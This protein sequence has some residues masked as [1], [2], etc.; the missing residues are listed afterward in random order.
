MGEVLDFLEHI[1]G[2][3]ADHAGKSPDD[4]NLEDYK[5]YLADHGGMSVDF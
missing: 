5:A 3:V 1:R 4:V 2:A